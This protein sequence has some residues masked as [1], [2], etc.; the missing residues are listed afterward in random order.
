MKSLNWVKG[1]SGPVDLGS[2]DLGLVGIVPP[3]T[4]TL[5]DDEPPVIAAYKKFFVSSFRP[6]IVI[7]TS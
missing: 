4:V 2:V 7:L 1:A 5:N 6:S 3:P